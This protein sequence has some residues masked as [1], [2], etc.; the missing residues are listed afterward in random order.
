MMK[1][2][3]FALIIF[4]PTLT[5]HAFGDLSPDDP[6]LAIFQHLQDVGIMHAFSDGNFY[7]EKQVTRAEALVIAMRAGD[8]AIG[9]ND[10][11]TLFED[12]DPNEW[13][14]P[15]VKRAIQTNIISIKD[16]TQFRPQ[17][18][19]TKAEFLA[20]LFRATRVNFTSYFSKTKDI[21][22][23]VPDDSWF[24]PHFAYAKKFQIAH[25]PPDRLY[26]PF[27]TLSR[28]EI[29]LM[30]FRQRKIL[31][32]DEVSKIF[33][34]LQ[35]E[36]EQ[37]ITLLRAGKPEMAEMHLLAIT[38][39][40]ERLTHVRNNED[41]VAASA[42]SRA[43]N[44]FAD[45][46]RA[47]KFQQNLYALESLHL[48]SKQANRAIEKSENIAPFARELSNLINET[49]ASFTGPQFSGFEKN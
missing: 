5:T 26:R 39:L 37:F 46:L 6:N 12:V 11:L 47:L 40:T 21:A 4:L 17:E 27:K 45:G 29:A 31:Y 25:L 19:I 36:I 23:D 34:E 33:I 8:I 20:F 13:Y 15:V 3:V 32:G 16:K 42:I 18:L 44:H 24:A 28:R 48:A 43:L 9:E 10:G 49:L 35:A 30:T 1:K 2:L 38:E 22:D 7:P 41:A 14:A